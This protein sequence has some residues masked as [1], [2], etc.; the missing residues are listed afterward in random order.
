MRGL[1]QGPQRMPATETGRYR[2]NEVHTQVNEW[3]RYRQRITGGTVPARVQG[4]CRGSLGFRGLSIERAR[5]V[6]VMAWNRDYFVS[7][8]RECKQ[9]I[10]LF[11]SAPCSL[12]KDFYHH[13]ALNAELSPSSVTFQSFL[14]AFVPQPF[15]ASSSLSY[16]L[17]SQQNT[18]TLVCSV[19]FCGF[20][21]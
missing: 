20:C 18:K 1:Q 4:R 21:A 6:E 7:T 2:T 19:H 17:I 3:A 16:L 13:P 12:N 15:S 14:L 5:G 11:A 10:Y 9:F 8:P